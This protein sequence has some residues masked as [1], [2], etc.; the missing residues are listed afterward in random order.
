MLRL[1]TI[2]WALR[3]LAAWPIVNRGQMADRPVRRFGRQ[4]AKA[5]RT[6]T[7]AGFQQLHSL[8]YTDVSL[9][10]FKYRLNYC[11]LT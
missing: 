3:W 7:I 9:A 11:G 6:P 1:A 8:F 4:E 10:L 2:C 5:A